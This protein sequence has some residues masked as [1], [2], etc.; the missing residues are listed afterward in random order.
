M[1]LPTALNLI[2]DLLRRHVRTGDC[3]LDGTAGN[4]NDTLLLAQLVG[5]SGCVYA[6]DIQEQAIQNTAARLQQHGVQHRAKLILAGHERANEFI[7]QTLAAAVFNLGYLPHG[8]PN[9][10]T[11]PENSIAAFQAALSLLKPRGLLLAA[12]YHG[13]EQGKPETAAVLDFATQL[14]YAEYRVAKYEFINQD[15][16]PPIFLAIEKR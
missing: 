3:V 10:T 13:H 5:D 1:P 8:N 14:P 9:I 4:G 16:C 2:H 12:L 6:F 11:Q 15:N 7:S